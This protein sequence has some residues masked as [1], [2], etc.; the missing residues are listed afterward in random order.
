MGKVR[1]AACAVC[2]KEA[3]F[4]SILKYPEVLYICRGAEADA[5]LITGKGSNLL[6]KM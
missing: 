1:G 5:W 4:F 2:G 6:Q 3:G